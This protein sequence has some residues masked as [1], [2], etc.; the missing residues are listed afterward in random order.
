[1]SAILQKYPARLL[2][3]QQ[4]LISFYQRIRNMSAAIS[5]P[6]KL[7][8]YLIRSIVETSPP[9]RHLAHVTWFYETFLLLDFCRI[10]SPST[11]VIVICLI[12]IIKPLAICM[13]VST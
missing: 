7:D 4:D 10:T 12:P 11:R 3:F 9:K 13:R 2:N 6:L 8:D 5:A 1:M